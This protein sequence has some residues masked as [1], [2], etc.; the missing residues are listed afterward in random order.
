[1]VPK[2]TA[3]PRD[4]RLIRLAFHGKVDAQ[5]A[6]LL[7]LGLAVLPGLAHRLDQAM[8]LDLNFCHF[9]CHNFYFGGQPSGIALTDASS[10]A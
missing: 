7:A 9:I 5:R 2:P 1:M 3:S 10:F 4:I 8:G 6:S